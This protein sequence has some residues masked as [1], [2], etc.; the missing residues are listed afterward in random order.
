MRLLTVLWIVIKQIV[1][2]WR[3]ELGLLLGLIV[4]V[5]VISTVPIYTNGALQ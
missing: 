2:N 3:L 1:R 4:A 5:G